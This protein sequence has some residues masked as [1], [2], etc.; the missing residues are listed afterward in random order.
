MYSNKL[1]QVSLEYTSLSSLVIV[2]KDW[3][4]R[5]CK[6]YLRH[7]PTTVN[8]L[9][10]VSWK[11]LHLFWNINLHALQPW[12]YSCLWSVPSSALSTTPAHPPTHP[13]DVRLCMPSLYH[14]F[15]DCWHVVCFLFLLSVFSC[16]VPH[17][18][19]PL[20]PLPI[21]VC[22]PPAHSCLAFILCPASLLFLLILLL[23]LSPFWFWFSGCF[24]LRRD[25]SLRGMLVLTAC[26]HLKSP[27]ALIKSQPVGSHFLSAHT[28]WSS[29]LL[30]FRFPLKKH[31]ILITF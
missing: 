17:W 19:G 16:T 4:N 6:Q 18:G 14:L 1:L 13:H 7:W 26:L 31:R 10:Y 23:I 11:Q 3:I 15:V 9:L 12:S 22:S 2:I 21:P 24:E 30:D 20:H 5:W 27:G 8:F 28:W 25:S 29:F